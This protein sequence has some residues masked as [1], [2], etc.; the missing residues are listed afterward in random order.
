[1]II[2]PGSAAY[3]VIRDLVNHLPWMIT[4]TWVRSRSTPIALDD[5]LAYLVAVAD[6]DA[7]A[8][9]TFDAGGPETVTYEQIMRCYG[10]Q[11]GRRPRLLAVPVLSPKLSSYWL[12]LVTSVPVGVARAL[13]EGL[14]HEL[15]ADD[16]T[17]RR[18][19]PRRLL[20]LD[21]A[22]RAARR[23]GPASRRRRALGRRLES[24]AAISDP[25]TRSMPSGPAQVRRATCR[26]SG[27]CR[28]VPDRR[29][30]GVVLCR[31]ALVAA[32]SVRLV[33]RRPELPP[34]TSAPREPPRRRRPSIPGVSS[35][36]S[37]TDVSR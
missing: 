20:G 31:L 27:L 4:P 30:R 9:Q 17:I 5:L 18:L 2:G 3:E 37:R 32:S 21:E 26:R 25:S 29:R 34:P 15:V 35:P 1:M 23:G 22:I 10:S 14:A 13:V 36:S 6:L 28:V 16:A 8:G 33:G 11:A 24:P 19:V 12:R 7:A